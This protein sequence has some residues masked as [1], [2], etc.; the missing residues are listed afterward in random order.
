MRRLETSGYLSL[1]AA[2]LSLGASN[3]GY[4]REPHGRYWCQMGGL[5]P[6][7]MWRYA[8]RSKGRELGKYIPMKHCSDRK[9]WGGQKEA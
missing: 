7:Y 8:M 1:L 4:F 6:E 5:D 2:I 3:P 9:A